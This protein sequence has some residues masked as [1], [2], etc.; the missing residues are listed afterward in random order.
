MLTTSLNVNNRENWKPYWNRALV[1]LFIA[2]FFL[3]GITRY[4]HLI[5]A[6]MIVTVIYQFSRAPKKY[7]SRFNNHLFYSIL[8]LSL[9][10]I[11][12]I[13][14]SPDMRI[15][16]KEFNN[17]VLKGFLL[18]T[19]LIPVLLKD[20]DSQTVGKLILFSFLTS[21]GLRSLVELFL[22]AQDYNKGIMPFTTF[23]HR[24]ISD[25]MVFLFPA[26]LNLWL[27]KKKSYKAIFFVFSAVF[28]FLI[29]GTLSRG[30]WLAIFI[31]AILWAICNR[32]WKLLTLGA[33][34]FAATSFFVVTQ[35][36]DNADHERLLF[37][38]QQTDSSYR[39]TN[40]TQGTA[41]ILITENPFKG[42]GYGDDIYH[43]V[44][45]KRVQDYPSWTFKQ[46]IGPHN[47]ILCIWFAAGISG[48]LGLLYV[49]GAIIKETASGSLKNKEIS[50]YNGQL[51]LLLTFIGFYILRGNFEQVDADL[52]GIITGFLLALRNK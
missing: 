24:S 25:S 35:K 18:Y 39:Y 27:F 47:L 17:T 34:L 48:L 44:Y 10:L 38:L 13:L 37:K 20:E 31:V 7:I 45:N 3:D 29:L 52:L 43:E 33:I 14:I 26:L 21:L 42:Y 28:L 51:L 23:E 8:A 41:W 16:F 6:L 46:S 12:A 30:A 4:K 2:T 19:L 40:G 36:T 32:Q 50:P 11:Y 5:S 49:Y 22:Y 9:I 1:F 15:S